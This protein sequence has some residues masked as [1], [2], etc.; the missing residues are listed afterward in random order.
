MPPAISLGDGRSLGLA[1]SPLPRARAYAGITAAGALASA[2]AAAMTLSGSSGQYV[3]LQGVGRALM[4][5]LPA[6]VGL[7]AVRQPASAR[8]GPLLIVAGFGWFV[9]TL[10]E[11]SDAWLYSIG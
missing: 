11:S 9:T 3:A 7:Y 5:G 1:S 8:F 10:S 4:V 2:I 6:A